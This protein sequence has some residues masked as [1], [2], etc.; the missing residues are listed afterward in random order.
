MGR[1]A[2][3]GCRASYA[4]FDLLFYQGRSLLQ[5]ALVERRALLHELLEETS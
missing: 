5:V 2:G 1:G 4:V 3:V